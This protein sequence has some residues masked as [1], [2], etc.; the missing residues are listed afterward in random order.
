MWE[1]INHTNIP[2]ADLHQCI[3]YNAKYWFYDSVISS[4]KHILHSKTGVYGVYIFH[5]FDA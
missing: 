1:M 5:S 4:G 3:H 2:A